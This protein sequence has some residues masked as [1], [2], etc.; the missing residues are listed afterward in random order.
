MPYQQGWSARGGVGMNMT[1]ELKRHAYGLS[2][3]QLEML[4]DKSHGFKQEIAVF[5]GKMM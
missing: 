4:D 2:T 5:V 3:H 1:V